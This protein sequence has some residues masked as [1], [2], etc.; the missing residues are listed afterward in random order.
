MMRTGT[1]VK[2]IDIMPQEWGADYEGRTAELQTL[3]PYCGKS[4]VLV[5]IDGFKEMPFTVRFV[6]WIG[7]PFSEMRFRGEELEEV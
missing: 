1:A 7:V 4:G 5:D 6:Y 3:A 2:V